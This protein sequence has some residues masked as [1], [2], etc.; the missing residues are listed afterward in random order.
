MDFSIFINSFLDLMELHS[1]HPNHQLIYLRN[2]VPQEGV[3]LLNYGQVT[4]LAQALQVLYQ[5]Y[6]STSTPND[7]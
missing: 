2:S 1:V 5:R 3:D 6:D 4:T 7:L